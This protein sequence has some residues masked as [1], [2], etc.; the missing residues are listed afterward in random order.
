MRSFFLTSVATLLLTACTSVVPA[1]L[2]RLS[3]L[4]PLTADPAGFAVALE[5]NDGISVTPGTTVMSFVATH[6]PSGESW[7]EDL[8]LLEDR[9]DDGRLTYR[10]S[11]EGIRALRELQQAVLPWKET[12]DGNS[13]FSL[14]VT[15]D[16]CLM[17]GFDVP[18]DPRVSIFIQLAADA[19]MRPLVRNGPLSALFDLEE[20][21][22]LPQ[23]DS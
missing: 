21:A 22:E 7:R 6:S 20:L 17:P 10:I 15:A 4:D 3:A 23:C 5:T 2:V 11:P 14:G 9:A 19:P 1:T 8:V 16:G 13:S 18:E 12:S